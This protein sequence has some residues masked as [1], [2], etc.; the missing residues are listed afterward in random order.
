MVAKKQSSIKIPI[1][2]RNK[3]QLE[4]QTKAVISSFYKEVAPI[5]KHYNL[6]KINAPFEMFAN[7]EIIDFS[8][9]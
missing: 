5:I 2:K 6:K 1:Q 4:K 8:G 3:N 9:K 7:G